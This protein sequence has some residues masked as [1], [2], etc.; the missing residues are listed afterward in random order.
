VSR[1][2]GSRRCWARSWP[3]PA[4]A[5]VPR[6]PRAELAR[7]VLPVAVAPQLEILA[8]V[9]VIVYM[10]LVG[11]GSTPRCCASRTHV[12]VAVSHASIVL[13]F[14]LGATLSLWL[15]PRLSSRD[16]PFTVFAL[17]MGVSMSVTAFPV[18]ARI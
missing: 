14:V 16:V 10:F 6:T 4:R 12:A 2:S 5:L 7:A 1:A 11:S 13:P 17:F 15:Y 18:L 9:G 3:D 8:Q